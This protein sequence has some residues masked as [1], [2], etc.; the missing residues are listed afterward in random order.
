MSGKAVRETLGFL[1]VVAGLV[2]VGLEIRQNNRIAS[3][4]TRQALADATGVLLESL[5]SDPELHEQYLAWRNF[6]MGTQADCQQTRVCIY[7][8]A[9]LRHHENVFLQVQD[10]LLDT[11]ALLSYAFST[12]TVYRSGAF[13]ALWRNLRD[14]YHPDFI[15]AFEAEYDLAP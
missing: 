15:A 7:A 6:E 1:A 5:Y 14:R 2:F 8:I 12:A 13:P 3:A 4:S 9:T 10:G 11:S